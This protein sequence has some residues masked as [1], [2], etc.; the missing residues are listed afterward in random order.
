MRYSMNSIASTSALDVNA[1]VDAKI[2]KG[3]GIS[4]WVG[5]AVNTEMA[6]CKRT[7]VTLT[8]H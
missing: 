3:G 2:I 7:E 5:N 1:S 8:A 6:H 4:G